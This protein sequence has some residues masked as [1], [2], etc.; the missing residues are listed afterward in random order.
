MALPPPSPALQL[1]LDALRK[2]YELPAPTLPLQ[3]VKPTT[4]SAPPE[5][6]LLHKVGTALAA[7]KRYLI[8]LPANYNA[9]Q[10]LR[11]RA[12]R[13]IETG[14]EED[15]PVPAGQLVKD[16]FVGPPEPGDEPVV[17]HAKA[18][19]RAV[20][21][22]AVD[23][24]TDPV[25]LALM[26]TGAGL[27]EAA[28]VVA[29]AMHVGFA[30]MMA[31]GT[32]DAGD[33]A[34]TEYRKDGWSPAVSEHATE[35]AMQAGFLTV[36]AAGLIPRNPPPLGGETPTFR[37]GEPSAVAR[38]LPPREPR[39]PAFSRPFGD[40]GDE[41][42]DIEFNYPPGYG[43]PPGEPYQPPPRRRGMIGPGEEPPAA[44]APPSAP[45][46][47]PA[48]PAPG[49]L[50]LQPPLPPSPPPVTDVQPVTKT[51]NEVPELGLLAKDAVESVTGAIDT[52]ITE[53]QEQGLAG[54]VASLVR[55]RQA[56][57][58][59]YT[60]PIAPPPVPPPSLAP[61]VMDEQQAIKAILELQQTAMDARLSGQN[62]KA[63][64]L[65]AT[66]ESLRAQVRARKQAPPVAEATNPAQNAQPPLQGA[67]PAPGPL[68]PGP[69]ADVTVG[70]AP[71][72][73][74]PLEPAAAVA[75]KM[76]D[77]RPGVQELLHQAETGS[78]PLPPELGIIRGP[79]PRDVPTTLAPVTGSS[80][81][82]GTPVPVPPPSAPVAAAPPVEA[83][84]APVAPAAPGADFPAPPTD[85]FIPRGFKPPEVVDVPPGQIPYDPTELPAEGQPEQIEARV[86][87]LIA[88]AQADAAANPVEPAPNQAEVDAAHE[89]QLEAERF[90]DEG[91]DEG[92][93]QEPLAEG[94]AQ[95]LAGMVAQDV[96]KPE[97]TPEGVRDALAHDYGIVI[98]PDEA[99][100]VS[101]ILQAPGGLTSPP[102]SATIQKEPPN[103][104]AAPVQAE[105]VRPNEGDAPA[106]P[107]EP[108]PGE[109]PA[110]GEE[111]RGAAALQGVPGA[112]EGA[113]PV[114]RGRAASDREDGAVSGAGAG[115]GR[116]IPEAGPER[117]GGA[118]PGKPVEPDPPRAAPESKL[119]TKD[120]ATEHPQ[121]PAP[122]PEGSLSNIEP[123][124]V[125]VPGPA[126]HEKHDL[127]LVGK[128]ADPLGEGRPWSQKLDDNVAAIE[129]LKD[130]EATGRHATP[131]E[132]LALARFV[133]W[134]G[135]PQV[136]DKYRARDQADRARAEVAT[137]KLKKLMTEA[138]WEA[139]SLS[140][141][142]AHYTGTE[143]VRGIWSALEAM[144]LSSGQR[145]LE[146]SMGTGN[147]FTFAPI[148]LTKTGVELDALTA[149]IAKHIH[150]NAAIYAMGLEQTTL[151]DNFYDL[152]VGNPP[153]GKIK[154]FDPAY[155]SDAVSTE[156]IHNYMFI[157][158]LDKVRPGGIVAMVTSRYTMDAKDSAVRRRLLDRADLIA[159]VR[160]PAGTFQKNANT[161]VVTD[162]LVFRKRPLGAAKPA[163]APWLESSVNPFDP[164]TYYDYEHNDEQ[165]RP[166]KRNAFWD[167]GGIIL[168]TEKTVRGMYHAAEYGVEGD[169]P[170][171]DHVRNA[172]VKS[173][174]ANGIDVRKADGQPLAALKLEAPR[175][176]LERKAMS[177]DQIKALKPGNFVLEKDKVFQAAGAELEEWEPPLSKNPEFAETLADKENR[178]KALTNLKAKIGDFIGLRDVTKELLAAQVDPSVTDA[179]FTKHQKAAEK[180]Y[181]AF[182]KKHGWLHEQGKDLGDDT[183][184]PNVL[185]LEKDYTPP[186]REGKG[187]SRK[188]TKPA[189]AQKA[190]I[191]KQRLSGV[192]PRATKAETTKEAYL[193]SLG[194]TG[195]LNWP[196]MAELTGKSEDAVREEAKNA[197]LVYQN[198]ETRQLETAEAYL[199]GNVR[200]KLKQAQAAAAEDPSL[201]P[202]VDALAAVLP[203]EKKGAAIHA[204]IGSGWIP[205]QYINDFVKHLL[206]GERE[207]LADR[208]EPKYLESIASWQIDGLEAALGEHTTAGKSVWGAEYYTAAEAIDDILNL[209]SPKI[210][211][212]DEDG[213]RYLNVEWTENAKEIK[214]KLENEWADWLWKDQA[215]AD[216]IGTL[217]NDTFYGTVPRNFDGSHLTFDGMNRG[218]LKGGDLYGFQ[219]NAVW[220]MLQNPNTLV[221]LPVGAGK[222][223]TAI[224]A[225]M[226]ARRMGTAKKPV[227]LAPRA[228]VPQWV[229][230]FKQL[231]PS[232]QILYVDPEDM[233]PRSRGRLMSRIATGDYDAVVVTHE[234]FQKLP[235]SQATVDR[236]ITAELQ[237][238]ERAFEDILREK[239]PQFA[240]S[241]NEQTEGYV[242]ELIAWQETAAAHERNP[243][244]KKNR[245][246]AFI[247]WRDAENNPK[248]LTLAQWRKASKPKPPQADVSMLKGEAASTKRLVKQLATAKLNLKAKVARFADPTRKDRNISFEQLGVDMIVVDEAHYF[249]RLFFTSKMER[250]PGL[251]TDFSDRAYDLFMKMR[252]TQER[253][254]G[255]GVHFLTGTPLTNTIAEMYSLFRYLDP[256]FLEESGLEHFDAWAK[257]YATIATGIEVDPTGSSM[258]TATRFNKFVN[259][260]SL[261]RAFRSFT[262]Y[263]AADDL[264]IER[265]QIKLNENNERKPRTH[266]VPKSEILK[267]YVEFLVLRAQRVKQGGKDVKDDNPLLITTDGMKA[268]LDMRLVHP[269]YPDDPDSKLNQAVRRISQIAKETKD[270]RLT[271]IVFLDM[272]T[273]GTGTMRIWERREDGSAIR[274]YDAPKLNLYEDMRKKLIALGGLDRSEIEFIHDWSDDAETAAELYAKVNAGDVRVLFASSDKGGVGVNVQKKL[275]AL[276]HM[277]VPY[278]PDKLEQREGR[279]RRQGNENPEVEIDNWVTKGTFDIYKWQLVQQKASFISKALSGD[280][281]AD[282]VEDLSFTAMTAE[283]VVALGSDNPL[284][285]ERMMAQKKLERIARLFH[286][287]QEKRRQI[288]FDLGRQESML[289]S[290]ERSRP[291]HQQNLTARTEELQFRQAM[292]HEGW[293]L[294][295]GYL[296]EA[297]RS[298]ALETAKEARELLPVWQALEDAFKTDAVITDKEAA[299][300][301]LHTALQV[302]RTAGLAKAHKAENETIGYWRGLPVWASSH[303][304]G[305]VLPEV[306][307]GVTYQRRSFNLLDKPEST[308][309]SIESVTG[310]RSLQN[311]VD[312]DDKE[313]ATTRGRIEKLREE[314]D[315]KFEH[316]A[317]ALELQQQLYDIEEKL[318]LHKREEGATQVEATEDEGGGGGEGPPDDGAPY[319]DSPDPDDSGGGGGVDPPDGRPDQGPQPGSGGW[320]NRVAGAKARTKARGRGGQANI[321]VDPQG[322]WDAVILGVDALMRGARTFARWVSQIVAGLGGNPG[323]NMLQRIWRTAREWFSTRS[324]I[325]RGRRRTRPVSDIP[326]L[327]AEARRSRRSISEEEVRAAADAAAQEGPSGIPPDAKP[328]GTPDFDVNLGRIRDQGGLRDLQAKIV[329]QL[330]RSLGR[331]ARKVRTWAEVRAEAVLS[332]IDEAT[333]NRLV[334]KRGALT[335][336]EITAGR[337]LR[338]KAAAEVQAKLGRWN[339]LKERAAAAEGAQAELLRQEA[340]EAERDYLA[341][342]AQYAGI[343]ADTV[344]A[345]TEAGRAL[346]A[347]RM[348][349]EDLTPEERFA[350]RLFR[351]LNPDEKLTQ[352]L[353]D[354]LMRHD[355]ARILQIAQ[356]IIRPGFTR[357]I[358]EAYI[359]SI[360]SGL[361]TPAANVAGNTMFMGML[362]GERGL[363]GRIEQI[364]LRQALE[365]LLTGQASPRERMGGEGWAMAKALFKTKFGLGSGLLEAWRALGHEDAYGGVKGEF[366]VPAI[367]GKTGKFIRTPG[368]VMD[369]L[370]IGAKASVMKAERVAQVLRAAAIE[371]KEKGWS[372]ELVERRI[373]ELDR[374]LGEYIKLEEDRSLGVQ[375]SRTDTEFLVRHRG[376]LGKMYREMQRVADEA[377]FRDEVMKLTRYLLMARHSYPWLSF[378]VPFIKTPERIL[379]QA[380][381]RTPVG[382]AKT[383]Y[384]IQKGELRGGAASDRLAAGI[385]G[386]VVSGGLY[387]L[388]ADGY[389]TGGGPADPD[390]RRNWEKTGKKPYAIKLGNTWVSL[391]R[392]EPLATTLGFAADLAEARNERTAGDFWDKLHSSVLNN[393]ANKTYLQ[394]LIN[395][396]EAIGDPER[397]GAQMQK[398]LLGALVPNLLA[399]AARAIDP[400][401]RQ[402]DDISSLLMARIPMLSRTLP[403]RLSGTGEPVQ[404][405]EDPISRFLSPFRYSKE[406]GPEAN[407]E[408]LFLETGYNPAAPPKFVTVAKRKI[409]LTQDEREVYAGYAARATAF[410]RKLAQNQDWSGMS[411]LEKEEFLR[412]VYRMAH[413][414]AHRD[415]TMR[416]IKRARTGNFK[417]KESA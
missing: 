382:L 310:K 337:I 93:I 316:E 290:I 342:V 239:Y 202:N 198:P 132:Q 197:G 269:D 170:T 343:A 60:V 209:K 165:G 346:G 223:F 122:A 381:R 143:V 358:V 255:G 24:A 102:A 232:S 57:S 193:I 55:E 158:A 335:D 251:P 190:D 157:K 51:P 109:L 329:E 32:Y 389:I 395:T 88:Q 174:A 246:L 409:E 333:F 117:G 19:T 308:V 401:V 252:L 220:M 135:L 293:K 99:Q 104:V 321:G 167:K 400:T 199:S 28:P 393:I 40:I 145:V 42:Y 325:Y 163:T 141:P 9:T 161:Q 235:L 73:S 406:A 156:S 152:V 391:A 45:E 387:M 196:R 16:A 244:Y 371:G 257:N 229:R 54:E 300:A 56:I 313:I 128:G 98:S 284:V 414:A 277:D 225:V 327:S 377:T 75:A 159:A 289:G 80:L 319:S 367:P 118:E 386:S 292:G 149:R 397:Y 296:R 280:L 263:K 47:P 183:D 260:G 201:Q 142:N 3:P 150:P 299:T 153:F 245:K 273:P 417:L 83:P 108:L 114:D 402:T 286:A 338:Q 314:T 177:P 175:T 208:I 17:Q 129:L 46:P 91:Q 227:V 113:V 211:S 332:G 137:A 411:E 25:N 62:A 96:N 64:A 44:A 203:E 182:V 230:S 270:R 116:G 169:P 368:R 31:K 61:P 283:E 121:A 303:I 26:A 388:A 398:Q 282:S 217:F 173:L 410:A 294:Y 305:G 339:E 168:G 115:G 285:R 297:T 58:E 130:L 242:N 111:P 264:G 72:P 306:G 207:F 268:A 341:S 212:K 354:A 353:V 160:L 20:V 35:A 362:A 262:Y 256:K 41:F 86:D 48:P 106:A 311:D 241:S 146:P 11:D 357:G 221:A 416:V 237:N 2:K 4:P 155:R 27:A 376:T 331:K 188:I 265:P 110:H 50:E 318:G 281:E 123:P 403:P 84:A 392:I 372:A 405:G 112:A 278:T 253:N 119:E 309:A 243:E 222:T 181:D 301:M 267:K 12:E 194:E 79:E 360:L 23:A 291:V 21:G 249:K 34:Y 352:L 185:A 323:G 369:A 390:E 10:E 279:I 336:M 240:E 340:L 370:D 68:V 166:V 36:A 375:L 259:L 275:Y 234:G 101:D 29:K 131:D 304:S 317:E 120:V 271:Q 126:P 38:P 189:T 195:E 33:A 361:A 347:H 288:A 206:N 344:A 210:Y 13:F 355:H 298:I 399:S 176:M 334:R 349:A 351:G 59:A 226:E 373:A 125:T 187:K 70:T 350:R 103:A 81:Q 326:P 5:T 30:G 140:T 172:V 6:G 14:K 228:V 67:E 66:A 92:P 412:R 374:D 97:H 37:P 404:R 90:T 107:G 191:F 365:K 213:N 124:V 164:K 261:L 295:E 95:A 218:G 49:G 127:S 345:A 287:F 186:V 383:L 359:N 413:D 71:E 7:P 348:L 76:A 272:G 52:K 384:N 238:L 415:V 105:G 219:K 215:R 89:R 216:T 366:H 224:A 39:G 178:Q 184:F 180:A 18:V 302:I 78:E 1:K 364:G 324:T 8:D 312:Y 380:V 179:A 136:F 85:V 214:A 74:Q 248:K 154:V 87:Q 231:Y 307:H 396:A 144:G 330:E 322:F 266:V 171:A 356:R 151:P 139:A 204:P 43:G 138:E 53:A 254:N 147:F 133:G 22:T 82:G 233:T 200:R 328:G 315:A 94:D 15:A 205:A 408:R 247:D 276:H 148:T 192:K 378:V 236:M 258:R 250:I 407:L 69:G 274:K 134:G 77:S 379:V 63:A 65:E 394:G 100:Q 320:K 363:A 162:L 385:I